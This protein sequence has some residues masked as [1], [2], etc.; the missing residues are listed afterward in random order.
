MCQGCSFI[1]E[2]QSDGWRSR[3]L[4]LAGLPDAP[5]QHFDQGGPGSAPHEEVVARLIPA[6]V[7]PLTLVGLDRLGLHLEIR[8]NRCVS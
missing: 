3:V 4:P 2:E 7:T 6:A 1:L 5:P 8:S